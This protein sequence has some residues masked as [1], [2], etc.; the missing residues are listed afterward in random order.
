MHHSLLSISPSFSAFLVLLLVASSWASTRISIFHVDDRPSWPT[1][2]RPDS[3]LFNFQDDNPK[4]LLGA[5][6]TLN[7]A[8]SRVF[9]LYPRNFPFTNL[10]L[11]LSFSRC[12]CLDNP[13]TY[14]R[15]V[16][17][18]SES[19][20]KFHSMIFRRP[21]MLSTSPVTRSRPAVKWLNARSSFFPEQWFS[22]F[23]ALRPNQTNNHGF[24]LSNCP[25]NDLKMIARVVV[26]CPWIT[27]LSYPTQLFR[28]RKSVSS[29]SDA[30]FQSINPRRVIE[31]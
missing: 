19:T 27:S 10:S 30:V 3:S 14:A 1:L 23:H 17:R 5:T 2:C 16:R 6:V 20:A 12:L 22:F 29:N 25:T 31:I 7:P 26:T 4:F 18:D 11:S 28:Y 9:I 21:S 15:P 13:I 8:G 24:S